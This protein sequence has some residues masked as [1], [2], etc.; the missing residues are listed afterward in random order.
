MQEMTE[1]IA[2]ILAYPTVVFTAMVSLATTYWLF[3]VVGAL[4][5]DAVDGLLGLDGI[6]S[7][8]DGAVAALDGAADGAVD[9]AVDGAV[10]AAVDGAVDA[11]VDG[12]V[13]AAADG[14]V[15]R[16]DGWHRRRRARTC[17]QRCSDRPDEHFRS[18]RDPGH[19]HR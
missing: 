15:G 1:F 17:L 19:A 7:A 10:D 2:A 16:R 8:V 3:V 6:D 11:A 12:A 14:A 13:D 18:T 5:T 4:D 9:A